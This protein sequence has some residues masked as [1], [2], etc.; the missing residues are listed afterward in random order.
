ML[1]GKN[2]LGPLPATGP[3]FLG[4]LNIT[5]DSFS[6]GGRFLA[7]SA[8]LAQARKLLAQGAHALDVGAES[9]RPQA[10]PVSPELEW[11]R[12]EPVLR[13]LRANLP[14]V[15]ISLDTRHASVAALG[16]GL[17]AAV[18]NDVS[19]CSDPE[20]LG[21]IQASNCGL[22]AMR[23]RMRDGAFLMPPYEVPGATGAQ[24][25]IAELAALKAR[26]LHAGIEPGRILLDPGFGFGMP[27]TEE[28][29]L[30]NALADLPRELGWPAQG[31]C[32]GISRKR[33]LA[34]RAGT[35]ALPVEQ[36]DA[37][38]AEAHR[39]A[40]TLGYRIFRT[41]TGQANL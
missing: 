16:L 25:P 9:T 30:W 1:A 28:L 8:A 5:P 27:F 2:G 32:I 10:V 7:P 11:A 13:C 39:Q 35:P 37:L 6:D 12:L 19:G 17:G 4:I 22:I 24:A 21:L 40:L 14:Q 38:T 3:F 33:F 36:R 23:S 29:A 31:F 26:L 20:M 18:I 34:R 41:H 15:P